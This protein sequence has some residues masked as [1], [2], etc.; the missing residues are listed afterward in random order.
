MKTKLRLIPVEGE[1]EDREVELAETP[2]YGALRALVEP[3]LHGGDM[4]RGRV[5]YQDAYRDMLVDE[6]GIAKDL[7]VNERATAIYWANTLAHT[8]G[9]H[10]TETWAEIRGPAVLF[11]DRLVWF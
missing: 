11:P 4:E 1:P 9:P 7:P 8:P 5:W 2:T 10:L 3:L 6:N